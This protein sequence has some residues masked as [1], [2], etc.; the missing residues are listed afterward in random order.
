MQ[1]FQ[2]KTCKRRGWFPKGFTLVELVL[3]ML[4]LGITATIAIPLLSSSFDYYRL[5]GA[6]EEVVRALQYGQ[7]SAMTN[8]RKTRVEIRNGG[9]RLTVEQVQ[10]YADLFNGGD[11]LDEY[12][13]EHADYHPMEY[14]LKKGFDYNIRFQDE[15]RFRGVDITQSNFQAANTV[16]FDLM[17]A[18]SHG[19]TVTLQLADF[20]MI[21]KL[22][23]L[24][25][26]VTVSN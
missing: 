22:D 12:D 8:G 3:V 21:V 15:D 11:E 14:P 9:D 17:G 25:G 6:T 16:Y 24:T 7:L 4:I 10:L 13:L 18:P 1:H 20:Q 2:V 19:G 5:K 26:K 23:D